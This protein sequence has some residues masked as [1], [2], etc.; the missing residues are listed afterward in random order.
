MTV[1][2]IFDTSEMFDILKRIHIQTGKPL[3]Y[4]QCLYSVTGHGGRDKMMKALVK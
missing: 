1:L 4:K 3:V 2:F